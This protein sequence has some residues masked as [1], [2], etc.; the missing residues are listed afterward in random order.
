MW[1]ISIFFFSMISISLLMLLYIRKARQE[2][3]QKRILRHS[4]RDSFCEKHKYKLYNVFNN[5]RRMKCL[6]C[7]YIPR[8]VSIQGG[9]K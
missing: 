8:I 2:G 9:K 6:V 3:E 5:Q 1:S 4:V 7:G